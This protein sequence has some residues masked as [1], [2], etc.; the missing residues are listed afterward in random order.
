LKEISVHP[1]IRITRG[2]HRF[3][4]RYLYRTQVE[5]LEK[6]FIDLWARLLG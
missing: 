5:N 1:Q 6:R 2:V 4:E 3:V